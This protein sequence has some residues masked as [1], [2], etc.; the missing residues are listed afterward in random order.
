[1]IDLAV[2]IPG[3][4]LLPSP[5]STLN[6]TDPCGWTGVAC[7]NDS[8]I[9]I[10]LENT[11]LE[12]TFPNSIG[13]LTNM[14]TLNLYN[15]SINS[16]IPASIGSMTRLRNLYLASNPL[17]GTIPPSI[18][19]LMNLKEI[20]LENN[21]LTGTI[22]DF[23]VGSK[24]ESVYLTYTSLSGTIPASIANLRFINTLNIEACSINGTLPGVGPTSLRDLS[25]SF[26]GVSGPI[27]DWIYR[28]TNLS[29]LRFTSTQ[30]S[31]TL[32]SA[33]VNLTD[34]GLLHLGGSE[35]TSPIPLELASMPSLRYL[36]LSYTHL[37]QGI[38]ASFF[39]QM[40]GLEELVLDSC[41]LSGDIPDLTNMTSLRSLSLSYNS[42]S[43][44]IPASLFRLPLR[45]LMLTRCGFNGTIP[46]SVGSATMDTL[47]LESNQLT[48]CFLEPTTVKTCGISD[49]PTSFCSCRSRSCL[50][51]CSDCSKCP[52]PL[53]CPPGTTCSSGGVSLSG[54]NSTLVVI[55]PTIIRGNLTLDPNATIVL[56]P[57]SPS[58]PLVVQG[59]VSFAGALNVT[60]SGNQPLFTTVPLIQ[61]SGFCGGKKT[62]FQNVSIDLGPCRR[63]RGNLQYGETSL[64]VLL[65][66]IDESQCSQA[67]VLSPGVIGGIVAG[68]VA[69]VIIILC[70]IL[71]TQRHKIIPAFSMMRA[72]RR[73]RESMRGSTTNK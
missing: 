50:P 39:S 20:E 45:E 2:A 11:Q 66:D 16:T 18:F 26:M 48:G 9:S 46:A 60:F 71:Y 25:I 63:A 58:A 22:P 69:V 33:V 64:V 47:R 38:S 7:A 42:F 24:L 34:L 30:L 68:V 1:M 23:P 73:L 59:C 6:A 51:A 72:Q 44:T 54:Q 35:F 27:P 15:N 49:N 57:S 55:G 28:N 3:L 53:F 43:G 10:V 56:A 29:R 14:D 31:G 36:I 65:S 17:F 4:R 70:I 21:Y 19:T 40:D 13:Q 5:W 62:E 32:S 41:G 8:V 52:D 61:Y 12:G 67:G 37:G